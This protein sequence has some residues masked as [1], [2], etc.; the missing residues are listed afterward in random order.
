M[1]SLEEYVN[2]RSLDELLKGAE[3]M[4]RN[5]LDTKVLDQAKDNNS[6]SEISENKIDYSIGVKDSLVAIGRMGYNATKWIFDGTLV[7]GRFIGYCYTLPSS[8]RRL[9]EKKKKGVS[10]NEL[11]KSVL[12][13]DASETGWFGLLNLSGALTGS[14]ISIVEISKGENMPNFLSYPALAYFATNTLSGLYEWFRYEK[15]KLKNEGRRENG[16]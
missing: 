6:V 14:F 13:E 7:F 1:E 9:I 10:L 8:V 4:Q 15:N 5:I 2:G 16:K 3:V 12:S 11:E